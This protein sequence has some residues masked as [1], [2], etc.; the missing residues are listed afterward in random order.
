MFYLL[1]THFIVRY[2]QRERN[3]SNFF[4][5]FASRAFKN[6]RILATAK[7]PYHSL[8]FPGILKKL[9]NFWYD[10]L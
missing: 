9:I 4:F 8:D 10:S 3:F 6:A 1:V 7:N 2:F 5:V